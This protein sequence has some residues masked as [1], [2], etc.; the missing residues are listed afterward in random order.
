VGF[1]IQWKGALDLVPALKFGR[2]SVGGRNGSD[3]PSA[4][5]P[6]AAGVAIWEG[7][8]GGA[9]TPP[10]TANTA[11][12][13]WLQ[14]YVFPPSSAR[15]VYLHFVGTGADA[16]SARGVPSS[17]FNGSKL[18]ITCNPDGTGGNGNGGQNGE[19]QFD[20]QQTPTPAGPPTATPS[21]APT[22]TPQDTKT[23]KPTSTPAP[24]AT[25]GP[26]NTSTNTPKPPTATAVP[27]TL[28]PNL[29]C[30]AAG[31]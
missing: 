9:T 6:N 30:G 24:P 22:N 19:I 31:C 27:P 5:N 4:T 29:G 17:A 11:S 28:T 2:L 7:A 26:T 21:P 16:L 3:V 25:V 15:D 8:N 12:P 10:T 13:D 23:P 1:T 14:S 20:T 18:V